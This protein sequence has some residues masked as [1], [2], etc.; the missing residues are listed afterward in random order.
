M[1]STGYGPQLPHGILYNEKGGI[2]LFTGPGGIPLFTVHES[3]G[4]GGAQ[5][6]WLSLSAM[7]TNTNFLLGSQNYHRR[8][9]VRMKIKTGNLLTKQSVVQIARF[10]VPS[11]V[12]LP[13]TATSYSMGSTLAMVSLSGSVWPR[14]SSDH[15]RQTS[16][17]R[18]P[19]S[20]NSKWMGTRLLRINFFACWSSVDDLY[21]STQVC[22]F[23]SMRFFS[24]EL[25]LCH[26]T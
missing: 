13:P 12:P 7:T 23:S 8:K 1:I 10:T 3:I 24:A 15:R 21:I 5:R 20:T 9:E 11:S 22:A 14:S 16:E 6:F 26:I 19:S 17:R 25:S 18:S 2:P 4:P